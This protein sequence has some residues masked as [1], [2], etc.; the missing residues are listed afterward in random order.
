M[1]TNL[2]KRHL[3]R[4]LEGYW[5]VPDPVPPQVYTL[6]FLFVLVALT[7]GAFIATMIFGVDVFSVFAK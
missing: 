2:P 5:T 6:S 3:L 4:Q 7:F 1:P